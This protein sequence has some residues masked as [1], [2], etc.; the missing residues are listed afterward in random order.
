[1]QLQVGREYLAANGTRF[2]CTDVANPGMRCSYLGTDKIEEM[3]LGREWILWPGSSF[4]YTTN[5]LWE[6]GDGD[7]PYHLVSLVLPSVITYD[8]ML[9]ESTL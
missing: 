7:C 1:M 8:H 9:V 6:G 5:G 2:R 4:Y 3:V